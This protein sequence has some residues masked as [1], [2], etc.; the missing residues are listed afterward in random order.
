MFL[1]KSPAVIIMSGKCA[2][3]IKQKDEIEVTNEFPGPF[4]NDYKNMRFKERRAIVR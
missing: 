3:N 2:C 1:D 4:T